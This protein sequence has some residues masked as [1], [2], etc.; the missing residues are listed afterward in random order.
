MVTRGR[1]IWQEIPPKII[2]KLVPYPAL[3]KL[4]AIVFL[5]S[6]SFNFAG[7][8]LWYAYMQN[9][10]DRLLEASLDEE[11]YDTNDLITIKVPLSLPYVTDCSD[12]QR[13]NGEIELGGRVYK[14]VKRKI[15][16][17]RLIL[18]CLP[19]DQKTSLKTAKE[20]F[21]KTANDLSAIHTAKK[22]GNG[23]TACFKYIHGDYDDQRPGWVSRTSQNRVEY[24][25]LE[26]Q[27]PWPSPFCAIPGQ[28]P[29]TR[30]A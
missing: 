14:F 28:P 11:R 29:D 1:F 21:F 30:T 4:T 8:R 19:D 10:S 22:Q 7:Y 2:S 26:N 24:P 13:V 17:G 6:L 25:L 18:L 3:R 5:A 16:Q 9:R 23:N 15:Y 12:F 27:T 20:D